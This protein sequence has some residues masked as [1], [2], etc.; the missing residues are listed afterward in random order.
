MEKE[1]IKE[2]KTIMS[3]TDAGNKEQLVIIFPTRN[4]MYEI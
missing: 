3:D 1:K 4:K 2:N